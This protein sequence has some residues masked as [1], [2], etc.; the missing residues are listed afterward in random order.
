[1]TTMLVPCPKCLKEFM[2]TSEPDKYCNAHRANCP[3]CNFEFAFSITSSI[4]RPRG[5]TIFSPNVPQTACV[6]DANVVSKYIQEHPDE[7]LFSETS[8]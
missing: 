4:V 7:N 2:L 3:N 5:S 8:D 6:S 1:M